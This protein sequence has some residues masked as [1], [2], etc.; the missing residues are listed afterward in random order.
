MDRSQRQ[1]YEP[2]KI[3]QK[4]DAE[5]CILWA[6]GQTSLYPVVALRRECPCAHCRDEWTGQ[7]RVDPQSIPDSVR[8]VEINRVGR[9]ALHFLWNDNHTSGI[10]SFRFLRDFR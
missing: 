2:I 3:W 6:D 7:R 9:Y 10:Y 4:S 8:P 5:L 1:Q